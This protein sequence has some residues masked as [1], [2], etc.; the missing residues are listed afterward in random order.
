MQSAE[1]NDPAVDRIV[2]HLARIAAGEVP[3]EARAATKIFI[4]D[5][6]AAGRYL[7]RRMRRHDAGAH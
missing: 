7:L 1:M 6:L 5:T 2:A 4:A 3:K